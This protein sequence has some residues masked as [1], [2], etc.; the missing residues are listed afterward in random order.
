MTAI[1]CAFHRDRGALFYCSRC[2][3]ALCSDCVVKLSSGNYCRTCAESP[4]GPPGQVRSR[5][6]LWIWLVVGA[7]V[8][9]LALFAYVAR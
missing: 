8:F 3:K 7:A 9:L 6:Y 2:G 4:F 5:S 1:R